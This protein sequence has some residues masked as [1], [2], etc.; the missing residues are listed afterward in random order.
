MLTGWLAASGC[1]CLRGCRLGSALRA[2]PLRVL[3]QAFRDLA[4]AHLCCASLCRN[5]SVD[6]GDDD[7]A[8]LRRA[9]RADWHCCLLGALT[10]SW[11]PSCLCLRRFCRSALMALSTPLAVSVCWIIGCA[12]LLVA[13]DPPFIRGVTALLRSGSKLRWAMLLHH[14][15]VVLVEAIPGLRDS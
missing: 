10:G 6:D 14:R 7:C 11:P 5:E 12:T 3:L 2:L 1:G 4:L 9:C 13:A 15:R 8:C